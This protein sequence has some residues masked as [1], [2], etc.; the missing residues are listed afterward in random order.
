MQEQKNHLEQIK[1]AVESYFGFTIVTP[2]HSRGKQELCDARTIYSS[3]ARKL[4]KYSLQSIGDVINRNHATV[5]H[6]CKV[7]ENFKQSDKIFL[8]QWNHCHDLIP[9]WSRNEV[10][11]DKREFYQNKIAELANEL[12]SNTAA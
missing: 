8:R 12:E 3:L 9:E 5:L 11:K 7:A 1:E 6:H 2:P 10:I 4:T